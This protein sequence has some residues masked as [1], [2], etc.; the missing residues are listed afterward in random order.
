MNILK[1]VPMHPWP[2]Y[3]GQMKLSS[4]RSLILRKKGFKVILLSI[5]LRKISNTEYKRLKEIFSEVYHLKIS[6]INFLLN[7]FISIL[8]RIFKNQ[9]IQSNLFNHFH[10]K[11]TIQKIKNKNKKNIFVHLYTFRSFCFWEA[12]HNEKNYFCVDLID[13]YTRNYCNKLKNKFCI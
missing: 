5:S 12:V 1:I 10:L 4:S 13:S 9:P 7:I 2:L 6:P 11:R 8:L 3:A